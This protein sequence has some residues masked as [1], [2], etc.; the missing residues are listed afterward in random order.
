MTAP[1]IQTGRQCH[2]DR[3][4]QEVLHRGMSLSAGFGG[5]FAPAS[6][7]AVA[8][9]VDIDPAHGDEPFAVGK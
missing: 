4:G 7:A 6:A 3:P 8:R 9:G 1:A 5:G 2:P